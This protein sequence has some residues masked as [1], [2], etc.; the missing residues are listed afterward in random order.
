MGWDPFGDVKKAVNEVARTFDNIVG[1]NLSGKGPKNSI[2]NRAGR[3]IARSD[4]GKFIGRAGTDIGHT[5]NGIGAGASDLLR[6]DTE[7]AG[8]SFGRAASGALRLGSAGVA[9]Y[10]EDNAEQL[11]SNSKWTLGLTGNLAG[12]AHATR[13]GIDEQNISKA[14]LND[15]G[16]LA[17]KGAVIGAGVV[18]APEI[19]SAAKTGY[20]YVTGESAKNLATVGVLAKAAKNKDAAAA[21]NALAPGAGDFIPQVPKLD[22][23]LSE[24]YSEYLDGSK[25]TATKGAA[26]SYATPNQSNFSTGTTTIAGPEVQAG[27]GIPIAIAGGLALL[28]LIKG[29]R[30]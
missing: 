14:D 29:A 10:A 15:I 17:V 3:E 6:G 12:T 21:L 4:V 25:G 8:R 26:N 16:Q 2:I 5:V 19:A 20:G 28:L 9:Y 27:M 7:Q 13:S 22:P 23:T 1:T 11:R 24:L 18:Y 30:K